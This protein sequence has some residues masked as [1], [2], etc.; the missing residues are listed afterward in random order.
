MTF[1][2][3]S[4][5]LIL[6]RLLLLTSFGALVF[7]SSNLHAEQIRT[8]R[9]T[10][11]G[12][13][14]GDAR[15]D[16]MR[17][18]LQETVSQ[19]ILADRIVDSGEITRDRIMSTLNGH[20]AS[21]E[22]LEIEQDEALGE[23]AVT[24]DVGVSE[25]SIR[26]F[27]ARDDVQGSRVDGQTLFAELQRAQSHADAI[28]EMLTNGL[29][30]FP[31]DAF[32]VSLE[33]IRLGRAGQVELD[34]RI[35]SI[36]AYLQAFRELIF[37][38][39]ER[40][41]T[42]DGTDFF[43]QF[44]H[45]RNV[46]QQL[47]ATRICFTN[48]VLENVNSPVNGAKCGLLP[49]GE[50]FGRILKAQFGYGGA[51]DERFP[52]LLGGFSNAEV[53]FALLDA[54]GSSVVRNESGCLSTSGGEFGLPRTFGGRF[55]FH[56]NRDND[57]PYVYMGEVDSVHTA[58]V[59]SDLIDAANAQR[60]VGMLVLAPKRRWDRSTYI[61]HMNRADQT[62]SAVCAMLLERSKL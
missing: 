54:N 50:Y 5:R 19:L 13:T 39:S 30:P 40:T 49:V 12:Q 1:C 53:I 4:L 6:T 37:A 57:G 44:A 42:F 43:H 27:I 15:F 45:P 59:G 51:P 20:V 26:N 36:T 33:A 56:L 41:I 11:Y 47:G 29:A 23:F 52:I 34:I 10:G 38:I 46:H 58:T 7:G 9:A 48:G 61:T 28:D 21:F 22:I 17:L 25:S 8:V 55:P 62:A 24:A 16:S 3:M 32:E 14:L 18:A 2:A 35:Q 31:A 60:F